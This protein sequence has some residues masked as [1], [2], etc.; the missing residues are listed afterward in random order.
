MRGVNVRTAVWELGDC[1]LSMS[2][3]MAMSFGKSGQW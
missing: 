2:M 3:A 1:G